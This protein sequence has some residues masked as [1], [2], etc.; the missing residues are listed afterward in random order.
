MCLRHGFIDCR[1]QAEI[2]GVDD[3]TAPAAIYPRLLYFGLRLAI[4][5]DD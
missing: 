1:M 3:G 5:T 4:F 2:V